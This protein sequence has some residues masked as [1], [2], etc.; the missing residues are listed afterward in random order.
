MSPLSKRG[1][2]RALQSGHFSWFPDFLIPL[3]NLWE[4]GRRASAEKTKSKFVSARRPF[5]FAQDRLHQRA[6]RARSPDKRRRHACRY[7]LA[8]G[9][10]VS[11]A[12]FPCI[13]AGL[14]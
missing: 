6:R 14:R 1:H 12:N 5:G 11:A 3:F 13:I 7:S 9:T 4:L 10:A 2:V 8:A